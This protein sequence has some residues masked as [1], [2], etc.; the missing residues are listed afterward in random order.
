[1]LDNSNSNY[2]LR[3][4]F[5]SCGKPPDPWARFARNFFDFIRLAVG[6]YDYIIIDLVVKPF[7]VP[8]LHSREVTPRTSRPPWAR[9]AGRR[10]CYFL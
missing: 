1:M 4:S 5:I 2:C 9:R 7:V 10:M 6:F 3:L 8:W